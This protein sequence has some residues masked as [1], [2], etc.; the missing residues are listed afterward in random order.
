MPKHYVTFGQ[1]HTHRVNGFT[2]DCDSVACFEAKDR[3]EGREKAFN[4]FGNKFST[5]YQGKEFTKEILKYFPRGII[6][7]DKSHA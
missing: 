7:I 4:Y 3:D 5:S 1:I 6:E 2:L